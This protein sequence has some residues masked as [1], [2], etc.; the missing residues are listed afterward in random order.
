MAGY[1]ANSA[2]NTPQV[3][4]ERSMNNPGSYNNESYNSFDKSHLRLYTQ[5]GYVQ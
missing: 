2:V 4:P 1:A 5:R 3:T